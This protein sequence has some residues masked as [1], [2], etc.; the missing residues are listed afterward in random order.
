MHLDKKE[1]QFGNQFLYG[2]I[3]PFVNSPLDPTPQKN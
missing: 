3:F 1:I 2:A